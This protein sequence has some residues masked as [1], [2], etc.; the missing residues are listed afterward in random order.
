MTE[1][2]RNVAIR[3]AR[4]FTLLM[5]ITSVLAITNIGVQVLRYRFSQLVPTSVLNLFD[6]NREANIPTLFSVLLLAI[7]T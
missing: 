2:H 1:I 6:L 7:A 4:I 5:L 3:P